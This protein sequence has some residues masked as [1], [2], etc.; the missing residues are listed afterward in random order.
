MRFTPRTWSLLSLMLF[1]AAVFFWLK[2][3]EY[4]EA[5]KR[6]LA[7]PVVTN[8]PARA[9]GL[10]LFS[11]QTNGVQLAQLSTDPG[12]SP[13]ETDK[14]YPNRLRNTPKRLNELLRD[15]HAILLANALIDTTSGAPLN[16]PPHLRSKGDPGSYIVQWNGPSTPEFRARLAEAGATIV[17]YVP[18]NAYFVKVSAEGARTLEQ[19]AGV[20]SVLPFE[21]YYKLQRSLL[22]GAVNQELLPADAVLRLTLLPGTR[23]QAFTGSENA[24]C[25]SSSRR[26]FPVRS[27]ARGPSAG[28]LTHF[29][30]RA[31]GGAGN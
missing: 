12:A 30:R 4:E 17:S 19:T 21:P 16:I 2:G 10:S 11:T 1:V 9:A 6:K 3:N 29:S 24:R 23:D 26:A 28:G 13:D 22:A 15:D 5:R 18:N 27:A 31:G 25:R 14:L 8:T 20:Q 7:P